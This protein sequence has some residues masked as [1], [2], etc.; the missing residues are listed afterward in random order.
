MQHPQVLSA[1]AKALISKKDLSSPSNRKN[2]VGQVV[3][4]T[5]WTQKRTE[6][7]GNQSNGQS[8]KQPLYSPSFNLHLSG[9]EYMDAYASYLFLS[10]ISSICCNSHGQKCMGM[11]WL[12]S[13]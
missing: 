13:W 5:D 4:F 3:R 11:N 9:N 8:L 12:A 10:Q 1:V 2:R 6:A 7:L